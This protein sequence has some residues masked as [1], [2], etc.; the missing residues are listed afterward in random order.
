MLTENPYRLQITVL[1]FPAR[2]DARPPLD[3]A[4][5]REVRG[6]E[7]PTLYVVTTIPNVRLVLPR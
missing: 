3:A 7:S 4:F 2:E 5:P 1:Q 6:R